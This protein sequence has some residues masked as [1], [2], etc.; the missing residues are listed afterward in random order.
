MIVEDLIVE[1]ITLN[2]RNLASAE[3]PGIRFVRCHLT[4]I[5]FYGANLAS[6]EFENCVV[7]RCVFTKANLDYAHFAGGRLLQSSLFR[8]SLYDANFDAVVIQEVNV[9]KAFLSG[10]KGLPNGTAS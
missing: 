4:A 5:D 7:E 1:D 6:A 8:A 10:S 9:D 2:G 3:L